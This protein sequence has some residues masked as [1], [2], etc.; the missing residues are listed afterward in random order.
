MNYTT[1]DGRNRA[2]NYSWPCGEIEPASEEIAE[3][4]K[5]WR[6]KDAKE[7]SR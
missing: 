7:V 3:V 4:V 2:L 5:Y 1:T 6:E